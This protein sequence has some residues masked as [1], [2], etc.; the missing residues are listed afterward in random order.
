M[1]CDARLLGAGRI[2]AP[3]EQSFRGFG[4]TVNR[5][6]MP[7]AYAQRFRPV[8]IQPFVRPFR[9]WA[10]TCELLMGEC[11]EA[12][13]SIACIEF[14][15]SKALAEEIRG[16]AEAEGSLLPPDPLADLAGAVNALRTFPAHSVKSAERHLVPLTRKSDSGEFWM[17]YAGQGTGSFRKLSRSTSPISG[18]GV[19]I[20][21]DPKFVHGRNSPRAG[22]NC[23]VSVVEPISESHCSGALMGSPPTAF[24][25]Q[26]QVAA[27][28]CW[29][30]KESSET[31]A[32]CYARWR[33]SER[34]NRRKRASRI[35]YRRA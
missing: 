33:G 18:R 21:T 35:R 30:P 24:R 5:L 4:D 26:T 6:R 34:P 17:R 2:S 12:G 22:S 23:C 8:A 11:F 15:H 16:M 25:R 20:T 7:S 3:H 29:C 32:K 9:Q 14:E 28:L 27:R 13:P 1:F 31:C 19:S 10:W